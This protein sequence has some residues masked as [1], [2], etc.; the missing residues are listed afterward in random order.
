M[1]FPTRQS[2]GSCVSTRC[3]AGISASLTGAEKSDDHRANL[4]EAL[5]GQRYKTASFYTVRFTNGESFTAKGQAMTARLVT[6]FTGTACNHGMPSHWT[7]GT[8]AIHPR[9]GILSV[10][11]TE[12]A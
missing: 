10:S 8:V 9:F 11:R 3:A 2:H 12:T 4:S 7:R 5:A 1:K 6:A